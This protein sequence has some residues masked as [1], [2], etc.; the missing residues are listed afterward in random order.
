MSFCAHAPTSSHN[1]VE[2]NLLRMTAQRLRNVIQ[3]WIA[4]FLG[5]AWMSTVQ[6]HESA[7]NGC[8]FYPLALI[9]IYYPGT[10]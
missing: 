10:F 7:Q 1:C 4:C 8:L 9:D 3:G 6:M 2:E 5:A